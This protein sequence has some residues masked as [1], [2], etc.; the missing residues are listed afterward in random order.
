MIFKIMLMTR[1]LALLNVDLNAK[2]VIESDLCANVRFFALMNVSARFLSPFHSNKQQKMYSK[3]YTL[4]SYLIHL[5][6]F[7]LLR[8]TSLRR[9]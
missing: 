7:T 8:A 4:I 6:V 5:T 3:T 1:M 2:I 9:A